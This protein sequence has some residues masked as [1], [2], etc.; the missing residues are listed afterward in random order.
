[1][2]A[3]EAHDGVFRAGRVTCLCDLDAGARNFADQHHI[4]ASSLEGAAK[5]TVCEE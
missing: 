5:L 4:E 2:K 1:V 3:S